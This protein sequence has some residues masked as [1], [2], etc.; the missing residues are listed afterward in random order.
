MW[1]IMGVGHPKARSPS[2]QTV[3]MPSK[4]APNSKDY[5]SVLTKDEL[6]KRTTFLT[7]RSEYEYVSNKQG[8]QNIA[9]G[10]SFSTITNGVA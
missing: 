2:S 4:L 7:N 5:M 10:V 9:F 3:A 1:H 8:N 6:Q